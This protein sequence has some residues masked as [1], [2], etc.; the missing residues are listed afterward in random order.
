MLTLLTHAFCLLFIWPALLRRFDAPRPRGLTRSYRKQ[1]AAVG[2]LGGRFVAVPLQV[3]IV[4]G[5]AR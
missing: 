4:P 3:A 1:W 2:Q 5:G